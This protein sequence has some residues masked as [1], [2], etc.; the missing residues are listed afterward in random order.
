M[1][2]VLYDF[3][4]ALLNK[5]T[6]AFI[7]LFIALGAVLAYTMAAVVI[8]S[9]PYL[10]KWIVIAEFESN[11]SAMRVYGYVANPELEAVTA[12]VNVSLILWRS[13]NEQYVLGSLTGTFT[14]A[15]E[16]EVKLEPLDEYVKRLAPNE[17]ASL[18]LSIS[19]AGSGVRTMSIAMVRNGTL[20]PKPS[21]FASLAWA[22]PVP[23]EELNASQ[24]SS[25]AYVGVRAYRISSPMYYIYNVSAVCESSGDILEVT[26]VPG[27][28]ESIGMR[29][30]AGVH[31][32]IGNSELC[33][34]GVVKS[35]GE[36]VVAVG[37]GRIYGSYS[38]KLYV[39]ATG[40]YYELGVLKPGVNVF[41]VNLGF[42]PPAN[43]S[44]LPA[45]LLI[46]NRSGDVWEAFDLYLDAS[47][48]RVSRALLIYTA[49]LPTTASLF[50]FSLFSPIMVIYVCYALMAKPRGGGALEFVLA[51][52]VTRFDVYLTRFLAGILTSFAAPAVV[53]AAVFAAIALTVKILSG[54]IPIVLLYL[55]LALNLAA[56]YSV[57]YA[58]AARS[59]TS[60]FT[61][62]AVLLFILY[63]FVYQ[64]IS[65]LAAYALGA[66]SLEEAARTAFAMNYFSP[67][68]FYNIA[69]ALAL[70]IYSASVT[71]IEYADPVY[72]TTAA[73]AWILVPFAVGWLL[74]RRANLYTPS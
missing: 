62:L 47:S 71:G 12:P 56:F 34:L 70:K 54:Q 33:T 4:R 64:M 40:R 52:P 20:E 6:L 48:P 27:I 63:T 18:R 38:A 44:M 29:G 74:F 9:R 51:R 26:I 45:K 43:T 60:I 72:M 49:S 1:K 28:S 53:I 69:Q 19:A 55:G 14:G 5:F 61:G 46:L 57:L 31:A 23:A 39:N 11:L 50:M 41:R 32:G 16:E 8:P 58:I 35:G 24:T 68:G 37:L 2:A 42:E 17:F 7:S 36:A 30:P 15:F 65:F 10:Y 73:A 22:E 67:L 3:R 25:G 13:E 59:R 21:P 66:R